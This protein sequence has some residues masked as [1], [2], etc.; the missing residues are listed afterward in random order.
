MTI[1]QLEKYPKTLGQHILFSLGIFPV[2]MKSFIS[3]TAQRHSSNFL[4]VK[5]MCV[6]GFQ[7]TQVCRLHF[8][9]WGP[10]R[11]IFVSFYFGFYAPLRSCLQHSSTEVSKWFKIS[12]FSLAKHKSKN[13]KSFTP[14]QYWIN[15]VSKLFWR[16][17]E[18]GFINSL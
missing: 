1:V 7:F 17:Y 11:R 16:Q 2:E 4:F 12:H 3:I 9:D 6:L 10:D 15:D 18:K 8:G 5:Y 13:Y 14:T